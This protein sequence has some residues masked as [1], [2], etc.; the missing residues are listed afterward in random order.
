LFSEVL[1]WI[2]G[3]DVVFFEFIHDNQHEEIHHNVG[4]RNDKEEEEKDGVVV[5]TTDDIKHNCH[6]VFTCAASEQDYEG[7]V[8]IGEII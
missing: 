6:P 2:V 1:K 8:E 4:L 7:I 5:R 3:I